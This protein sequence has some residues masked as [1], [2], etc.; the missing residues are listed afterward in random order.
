M[1]AND[2]S[3]DLE[4]A[5]R[6]ASRVVSIG[7]TFKPG[8]PPGVASLLHLGGGSSALIDVR[9]NDAGEP[10]GL[11]LTAAHVLDATA[12]WG[13]VEF[14]DADGRAPR[15]GIAFVIARDVKRDVAAFF[16]NFPTKGDVA[17]PFRISTRRVEPG[18][19]LYG[20][21]WGESTFGDVFMGISGR[22]YARFASREIREACLGKTVNEDELPFDLDAPHWE[23]ADVPVRPGDSGGPVL[24]AQTGE[25]VGIRSGGFGPTPSDR[26]PSAYRIGALHSLKSCYYSTFESEFVAAAR[27]IFATKIATK[28]Y[29]FD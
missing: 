18:S 23:W 25:L 24:D 10:L 1:D 26:S 9:A 27:S 21:G 3:F 5:R 17:K 15:H 12:N 28:P 20:L 13:L 19:L 2:L 14:F 6:A 7:A 29:R 16:A 22:A 11:W 8:S 4:N